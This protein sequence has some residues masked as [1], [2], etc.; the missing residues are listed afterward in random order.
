MTNLKKFLSECSSISHKQY[1]K[2]SFSFCGEN[3]N[4]NLT[5]KCKGT[6]LEAKLVSKSG[7]TLY[8]INED[9]LKEEYV[10]SRIRDMTKMF[11]QAALIEMTKTDDL[12]REDNEEEKE[13]LL[14]DADSIEVEEYT[15]A[16]SAEDAVEETNE[17]TSLSQLKDELIELATRA[18]SLTNL[19]PE[20]DVNNRSMIIGLISGIY[21]VAQDT[22]ELEDDLAELAE[23]PES[24]KECLSIPSKTDYIDLANKG[25]SQ[26]CYALN[27]V[28][29]FKSLV[30]MIRDIKSELATCK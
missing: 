20:E 16:D 12:N 3:K 9:C 14:D 15:E 30:G 24:V 21:E 1:G 8:A 13:L 17:I 10:I 5:G 2:C 4:V 22:I 23:E 6:I 25:L 19:F 28:D 29:N 26:A 7:A 11:E 27:N 18:S